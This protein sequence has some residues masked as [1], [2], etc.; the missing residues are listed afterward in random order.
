MDKNDI[1]YDQ[2]FLH[3]WGT[4]TGERDNTKD[5][6]FTSGAEQSIKHDKGIRFLSENKVESYFDFWHFDKSQI[7][8]AGALWA[9]E[10]WEITA[11]IR[12]LSER[13]FGS[14]FEN[15]CSIKRYRL[16]ISY[17]CRPC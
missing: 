13:R 1:L 10:P 2:Y 12:T 7:A 14:I 11:R 15:R 4:N 17:N 6:E 9:S 8:G 3:E 16:V 5:S